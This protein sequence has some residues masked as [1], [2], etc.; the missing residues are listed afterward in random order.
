[1]DNFD[2]E[3][4]KASFDD[5]RRTITMQAQQ[6]TMFDKEVATAFNAN[7]RM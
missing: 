3:Y 5:A 2:A 6:A 7:V 1:M 4:E